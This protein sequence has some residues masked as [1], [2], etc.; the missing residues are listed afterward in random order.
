MRPTPPFVIAGVLHYGI[1][2]V[3]PF[4]DGNG[5][6]AR[7]AQTA[8]L[9]RAGVLPGRMFSSSV[10]TQRIALP[11]TPRWGRYGSAR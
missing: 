5:R 3:H 9:M 11:T 4:A 1:T 10:T 8:L 6:A 2:D 7:L